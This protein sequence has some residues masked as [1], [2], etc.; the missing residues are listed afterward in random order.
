MRPHG[1]ITATM[2]LGEPRGLVLGS[3]VALKVHV[4][5]RLARAALDAAA[6]L[7]RDLASCCRA[8]VRH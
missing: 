7:G 3:S 5:G 2:L 6:R 1:V 4:L 8:A